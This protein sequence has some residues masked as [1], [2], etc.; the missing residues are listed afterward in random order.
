MVKKKNY[1]KKICVNN[2]CGYI[3]QRTGLKKK[4][5]A[6]R[7]RITRNTYHAIRN[8]PAYMMVGWQQLAMKHEFG[9]DDATFMSLTSISAKEIAKF[10]KEYETE[11]ANSQYEARDGQRPA[12]W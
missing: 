8:K 4:E 12:L 1:L 10:L 11:P 2:L 6:E 3:E 7:L 5:I 9:L